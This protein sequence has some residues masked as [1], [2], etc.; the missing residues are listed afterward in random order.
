[1]KTVA[2]KLSKWE[3]SEV[4]KIGDIWDRKMSSP[5][6]LSHIYTIQNSGGGSI[7]HLPTS[8]YTHFMT[9]LEGNMYGVRSCV[10]PALLT[11]ARLIL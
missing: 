10:Y 9:L 8:T 6:G 3:P 4:E 5:A 1:M 7:Q 2:L 11:N